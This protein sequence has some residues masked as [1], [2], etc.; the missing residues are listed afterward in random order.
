[1]E[2]NMKK[3][4]LGVILAVLFICSPAFAQQADK[5]SIG[6]GDLTADALIQ[7][8]QGSLHGLF[9]IPDGSN[10]ITVSIYDNTAASGKK[11]IPTFIVPATPSGQLYSVGI[12][13]PVQFGT[14]LYVDI[15]CSGTAHYVVYT[16]IR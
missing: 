9:F 8:G 4:F 16:G 11:L 12:S 6:S 5:Y 13:P 7:T 3:V 1:M 2:D 15:T 10:T 14:G